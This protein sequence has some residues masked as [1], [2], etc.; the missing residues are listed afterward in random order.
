MDFTKIVLKIAFVLLWAMTS[1]MWW[2]MSQISYYIIDGLVHIIWLKVVV[3]FIS[4]VF[5]WDYVL[6]YSTLLKF[7]QDGSW[8][9]FLPRYFTVTERKHL[10]TTATRPQSGR[11]CKVTERGLMCVVCKSLKRSAFQTS[12]RINISTKAPGGG[13]GSATCLMSEEW[14][15]NANKG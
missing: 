3:N 2:I 6:G 1:E 10:G 8:T 15:H 13:G 4:F 12:S 7:S 11:P 9:F 14:W 5:V